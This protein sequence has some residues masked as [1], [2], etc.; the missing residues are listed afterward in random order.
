MRTEL[1]IMS[2][3]GR[4]MPLVHGVVRTRSADARTDTATGAL[5]YDIDVVIEKN[6]MKKVADLKLLPGTP[7]EVIVATGSRTAL[8][9]MLEPITA[10]F[11]HGMREK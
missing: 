5:Y 2:A 8:E 6:E 1:R 7:I 9:Y 10:S 4:R 11:R 3:Q